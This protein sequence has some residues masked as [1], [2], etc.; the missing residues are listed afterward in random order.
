MKI[1]LEDRAVA[2]AE[3]KRSTED[4]AERIE[5]AHVFG[6]IAVAFVPA[7]GRSAPAQGLAAELDDVEPGP[8]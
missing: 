4:L 6:H 3:V 1:Q 5:I 8:R 7:D 2:E